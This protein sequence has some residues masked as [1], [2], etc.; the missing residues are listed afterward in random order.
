MLGFGSMRTPPSLEEAASFQ[1]SRRSVSVTPRP[2]A[3]QRR[4]S[5]EVLAFNLRRQLI[6]RDALLRD[7]E[8]SRGL[9]RLNVA[10]ARGLNRAAGVHTNCFW[11]ES[12]DGRWE[13][14]EELDLRLRLRR[15]RRL[16]LKF[17]FQSFA[18]C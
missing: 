15:S 1:S 4:W 6:I 5:S 8:A 14:V 11:A 9:G 7:A 16:N 2:S 18:S 3:C 13:H 17:L 12:H 10:E